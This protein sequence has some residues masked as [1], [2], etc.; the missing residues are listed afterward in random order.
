MI[1]DALRARPI[2]IRPIT[3]EF[4]PWLVG[5]RDALLTNLF[6]ELARAVA[7]EQHE[8]GDATGVTVQ[9][10]KDVGNK[11]R[12]FGARLSGPGTFISLVGSVAPG[13]GLAGDIM[14][15]IA[16]AAQKQEAGPSLA[17]LKDD[18]TA[19]LQKLGKQLIVT[20]DDV[21]RLEPAEIWELLRLIRA[22]A[23]FPNVTYVLCLDH[24]VIADSVEEVAKL[25]DG[26]AYLEK[27]IQVVIPVP[28]PEAFQLRHWFRSELG[29]FAFPRTDKEH[30]RLLS[31]VD[32]EGGRRL[33]TPR[34]VVRA[35]NAIRVYW[36]ALREQG[37]DL[38]DL[39]WLQLIK[40]SRPTYY[41]W[42]E[43]YCDN[44]ATIL[45]GRADL[46]S[47][48]KEQE[49]GELKDI[50]KEDS[51]DI[52][53]ESYFIDELLPGIDTWNAIEDKKSPIY[54]KRKISELQ[55]SISNKRAK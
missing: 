37:A 7:A 26:S 34:A 35:L 4:R 33:T 55:E 18:L 6:D 11:I 41:K 46:S 12:E 9:A 50:Y 5:D 8:Q 14:Q 32:R 1:L 28:S 42:I 27:I 38:S 52:S 45:S 19:S 54:K 40:T 44:Y 23:D 48:Q 53:E 43:R 39:V 30:Q 21:D 15:R 47:N 10:A 49:Y 20:I 25:T 16:E 29:E 51:I 13:L 31:V 22:V 17:S 36:P 2:G 24:E 3:V